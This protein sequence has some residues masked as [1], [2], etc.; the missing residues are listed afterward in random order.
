MKVH[1]HLMDL[2]TRGGAAA[3]GRLLDAAEAVGFAGVNIT[4]PCK[5]TVMAFLDD[6]SADAEAIGAV[7]TVVFRAGKRSGHNTDW[8][9]FAESFRRGLPGAALDRVVLVGAGGG[10]SA[11]G[12]AVLRLGAKE[13]RIMD[14]DSARSNRLAERLTVH[15]PDSKVSAVDGLPDAL[16]EADGLIHATP[17][18]MAGHPGLAVPSALLRAEL[19][20]ADIVYFPLETELLREARRRGCPTL[21]GGGM[22]VFQAAEAFRLFTGA[23]PD[24][25]RMLAGFRQRQA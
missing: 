16:A 23:S 11:V 17:S 2:E 3:L 7:N 5:Q 18:G 10:G 1:Y 25:E 14:D 24:A 13:L 20:V 22:A 12:H 8:F 19:W 4:H 21:D 6:L 15:F 9:G